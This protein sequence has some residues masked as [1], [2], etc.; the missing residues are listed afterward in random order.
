MKT[1][2]KINKIGFFEKTFSILETSEKLHPK[3][4]KVPKCINSVSYFGSEFG[5]SSDWFTL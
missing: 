3:T 2:K 4:L 1:K 5:A